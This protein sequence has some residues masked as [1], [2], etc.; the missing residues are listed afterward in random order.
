M[1]F[2][3]FWLLS[4]GTVFQLANSVTGLSVITFVTALLFFLELPMASL[5][6]LA[7]APIVS[8][9]PLIQYDTHTEAHGKL[10]I[11]SIAVS[12]FIFFTTP[13]RNRLL[14]G[15]GASLLVGAIFA[16]YFLVTTML[17]DHSMISPLPILLLMCI[18]S[19]ELIVKRILRAA[20]GSFSR[21][22]SSNRI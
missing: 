21:H 20:F 7:A 19:I 12:A 22:T 18:I 13:S 10:L 9:P 8:N 2:V 15:V 6:F 14:K 17:F 4:V 5:V 3:V 11:V 1:E 16:V